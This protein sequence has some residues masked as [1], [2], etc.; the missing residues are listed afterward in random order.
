MQAHVFLAKKCLSNVAAPIMWLEQGTAAANMQPLLIYQRQGE[1]DQLPMSHSTPSLS[2]LNEHASAAPSSI[3]VFTCNAILYIQVL[4]R[5]IACESHPGL[6]HFC[7]DHIQVES[8]FDPDYLL[9]HVKGASLLY[10]THLVLSSNI[11]SIK[12][13]TAE[14]ILAVSTSVNCMLSNV[15]AKLQ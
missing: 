9:I 5:T 13:S 14:D 10:A 12:E 4:S 3:S 6:T 2:Y 11:C 1:Y 15:S 8:R 7:L